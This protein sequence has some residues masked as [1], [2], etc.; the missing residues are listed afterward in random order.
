MKIALFKGRKFGSQQWQN[1]FINLGT[2]TVQP[3]P[4]RK[5]CPE[6]DFEFWYGERK[7]DYAGSDAVKIFGRNDDFKSFLTVNIRKV[8]DRNSKN[9]LHHVK[10]HGQK[11]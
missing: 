11:R 5:K 4:V 10:E 7:F 9:G 3:P 2:V 1:Y 8:K 6:V